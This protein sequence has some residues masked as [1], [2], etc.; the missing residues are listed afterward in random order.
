MI[1][2]RRLRNSVVRAC[3][4]ACVF[5]VGAAHAGTPGAGA[6]AQQPYSAHP[7]STRAPLDLRVPELRQVMAHSV[8]LEE[9]AA[10]PDDASQPVEVVAQPELM[11]MISQQPAPLGL[12]AA[13]TWS[14][15]HSSEAWRILLPLPDD[16]TG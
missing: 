16:P 15:D 10:S 11:P 14:V 8:L 5:A 3:I 12:V 9:M 6:I 4:T 13:L 7:A 2:E 1:T